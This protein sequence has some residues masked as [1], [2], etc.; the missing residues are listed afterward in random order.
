MEAELTAMDPA[1]Q[2]QWLVRLD[3]VL[4]SEGM[5]AA[6]RLA[7][8]ALAEGVDHSGVINLAASAQFNDGR[9]AE[10]VTLL[11]QALAAS[12]DNPQVLN[13]LGLCLKALGRS[14]EALSAFEK[15]LEINPN[16]VAAHRNR[17]VLLEELKYPKA[18]RSAYERAAA[19]DPN[20]ADAAASIAWLDAQAGKTES[21]RRY[22][23]QALALSPANVVAHLSLASADLQTGNL[24]AAGRR[25]SH[26]LSQSSIE[27][28]DRAI[29]LGLIGDLEDALDHPA[30][31]FAAYEASNSVLKALHADQF[32]APGSV[33]PVD[34]VVQ[35]TKTFASTDRG[36]WQDAPAASPSPDDPKRH[37]FLV[38]F[39]RSGTT[40][41]EN[42]L[43]TH[44]D[45]VSLEERNCLDAAA[46]AYLTSPDRV[47]QLARIG[48]ADADRERAAYWSKV[49]SYG[50]EPAG[51]VFIDKM[52]LASVALPLIAKLFP[53][54]LILFA[55][56]DPRDVVLS[57]FRRRFG[58]NP[59]MYQMLT[60]TGAATYYDA[61]MGLSEI[62]R[63]LLPLPQH[64]IRHE[65]LVED[66]EGTARAT[67]D[68]L[69]LPWDETLFDFAEH[70]RTRQIAT[71]SAAQ[72]T[73]GLNREGQ[74]VWRRYR[75]QMA[76]V[77]PML[78]PWVERFG[79]AD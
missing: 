8:Q 78:E 57:C 12:P 60:L 44:P 22:G 16:M 46:T 41:L 53:D 73:R 15:A 2:Q 33:T 50:I 21:A 13:S 1:R 26:L 9:F 49:R 72:V 38:G 58:M 55:R 39:P 19:L 71:P 28:Q 69:G 27:P 45:V 77:L 23:E 20:S 17:G 10:A 43:T 47:E 68:F 7:V 36:Q 52:P 3:T 61:V 14:D 62:Y 79:Y 75:E 32:G 56:R 35:L 51:R 42:V 65:S 5:E 74:G 70:A 6:G 67:C 29:A 54:A 31:A 25:L 63:E 11:E 48:A 34:H 59:S 76:P 40:L 4:R 37:V 24:E 64:L 66:F 18:A 30:Q